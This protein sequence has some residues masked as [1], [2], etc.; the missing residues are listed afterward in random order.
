MAI[1]TQGQASSSKLTNIAENLEKAEIK[2]HS[3][4]ISPIYLKSM[5]SNFSNNPVLSISSSTL[6]S[7]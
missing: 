3:L 1:K 6:N 5:K 4:V 7:P 2:A